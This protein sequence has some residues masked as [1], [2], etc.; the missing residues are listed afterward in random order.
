MGNTILNY[1][2]SFLVG[3]TVT[4]IIVYGEASN[5]PL[6][7][8]I[9]ALFPV[10]TW[11]SYFFLSSMVSQTKLEKHVLFVLLGTLIAW[12]PYML[13]FYFLIPKIGPNKALLSAM[14]CFF[15]LAFIFIKFYKA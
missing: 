11:I 12:V 4:L 5:S 3:G 15:I 6:L 7:S 9:A 8:R 14:I 1:L 13:V 2:F 10:F